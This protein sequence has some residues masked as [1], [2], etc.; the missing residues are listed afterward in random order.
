MDW[1]GNRSS[2]LGVLAAESQPGLHP[3]LLR[4]TLPVLHTTP[5]CYYRCHSKCLNLIS[6][7]CVRSKVSHQ[8]EYE[9]SICPEA[10]LDS[11]DYRCAECRAPISLRECGRTADVLGRGRAHS[12]VRTRG[13]SGS[14]GQRGSCRHVSLSGEAMGG[15][16]GPRA[17]NLGAQPRSPRSATCWHRQP[18]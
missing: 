6:K 8:A 10:G 12:G 3:P 16:C 11:Q 13:K 4:V 5:G 7:P 2:P 18:T 9:L 15:C 17:S 14:Q 1:S